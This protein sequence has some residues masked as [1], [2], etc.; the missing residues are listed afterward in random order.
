LG[1]GANFS[2]NFLQGLTKAQK[3]TDALYAKRDED[4]NIT[5]YLQPDPTSNL[6]EMQ[7]ESNG[8][9]YRYRNGPQV[10]QRFEWPGKMDNIGARIM[11]V[12][13]HGRA[14]GE[15]RADGPWG[16]FHLLTLADIE[17]EGNTHFKT[18]WNLPSSDGGT[19]HVSFNLR[20]DR[21]DNLFDFKLI[22]SFKLPKAIFKNRG[23]S[24]L[25]AY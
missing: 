16:L 21:Q 15:L 20:S 14:V 25:A 1:V 3:I 22:N 11:G 10:W 5:F 9:L 2:Y 18:S 17:K 13:D 8:Q 7:I 24:R 6:R 12:A 4:P 23:S 19:V